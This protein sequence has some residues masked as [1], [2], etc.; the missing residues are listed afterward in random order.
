MDPLPDSILPPQPASQV[1]PPPAVALARTLEHLRILSIFH[2]VVGALTCIFGLFPIIHVLVGGGLVY[3]SMTGLT[4]SSG[5]GSSSM[6]DGSMTLVGALFVIIGGGVILF[7]Q[8]IGLC[9]IY[10]G[11]CLK[12]QERYIFS[13]VTAGLQSMFFPF[14]TVLGV[15]TLVV[16]FSDEAKLLYAQGPPRR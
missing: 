10:S 16:L 14:G 8:A 3:A 9:T 7:F 2:Y 4:S 5:G 12:R 6:S 1:P 13:A 11:M 15:I